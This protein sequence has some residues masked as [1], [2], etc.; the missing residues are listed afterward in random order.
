MTRTLIGDLA[1]RAIALGVAALLLNAALLQLRT[2]HQ[3]L[4]RPGPES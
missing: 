3:A 1:T 2:H 4:V